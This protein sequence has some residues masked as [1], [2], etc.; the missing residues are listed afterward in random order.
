MT[1]WIVGCWGW[2]GYGPIF[3][4]FEL[5]SGGGSGYEP[6]SGGSGG[7]RILLQLTKD[8]VLNG[9]ILAPGFFLFGRLWRRIG[10]P[11]TPTYFTC[12]IG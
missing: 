8:L 9:R 5:G 12:L 10:P 11:N 2:Q 6:A 4:P 3:F 1:E 7:G